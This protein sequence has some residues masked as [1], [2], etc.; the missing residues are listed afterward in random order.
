MTGQYLSLEGSCFRAEEEGREGGEG[1]EIEGEEGEEKESIS[2]ERYL[3]DSGNFKLPE[4][5][6]QFLDEMRS[7]YNAQS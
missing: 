3:R 1:R 2:T 6:A 5:Y 4:S 7:K